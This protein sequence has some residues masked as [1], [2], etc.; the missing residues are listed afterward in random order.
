MRRFSEAAQSRADWQYTR[1]CLDEVCLLGGGDNFDYDDVS[2]DPPTPE[3]MKSCSEDESW[4]SDDEDEARRTRGQVV[5]PLLSVQNETTTATTTKYCFD[6]N[7]PLMYC[8]ETGLIDDDEYARWK[9]TKPQQRLHN[10]KPTPI[11]FGAGYNSESGTDED[12]EVSQH[13]QEVI[14]GTGYIRQFP[15]RRVQ[16]GEAFAVDPWF[17]NPDPTPNKLYTN[18]A[19]NLHIMMR[20]FVVFE[21][22][23]DSVTSRLNYAFQLKLIWEKFISNCE[24]LGHQPLQYFWQNKCLDIYEALQDLAAT[25]AKCFNTGARKLI[26][27]TPEFHTTPLETLEHTFE[28]IGRMCRCMAEDFNAQPIVTYVEEFIRALYVEMR[29]MELVEANVETLI[30]ARYDEDMENMEKD[31]EAE[32]EKKE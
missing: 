9:I 19:S 8:L 12:D 26:P 16:P 5:V 27:D 11:D 6:R 29:F 2:S 30:D 23:G 15:W 24:V 1:E 7:D 31:S 4:S 17:L 22:S 14:Y 10:S 28:T 3:W 20:Q 21:K 32:K 13:F 18:F 25:Q